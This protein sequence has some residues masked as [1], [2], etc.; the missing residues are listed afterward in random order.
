M[1][2]RHLFD[3]GYPV[4]NAT[5]IAGSHVLLAVARGALRKS[6]SQLASSSLRLADSSQRLVD[7][8]ARCGCSH[9][10]LRESRDNYV[11]LAAARQPSQGT[12]RLKSPDRPPRA[13]PHQR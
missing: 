4:A 6:S 5:L 9:A 10:V 7:A 1:R 2:R 12:P 3:H 8:V 11:H 13:Q